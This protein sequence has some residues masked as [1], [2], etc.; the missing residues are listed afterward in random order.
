MRHRVQLFRTPWTA[1][2][3]ASLSSTVSWSLLKFVSIESVMLSNHLILCRPLLLL[4]SISPSIR[5]FYN[6]TPLRKTYM[7]CTNP[8]GKYLTANVYISIHSHAS[9]TC[10]SIPGKSLKHVANLETFSNE[11]L[12]TTRPSSLVHMCYLMNRLTSSRNVF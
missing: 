3:Q 7:S 2:H 11:T 10:L 5:V 8:G 1:S 6:V 4:P 9:I 12:P